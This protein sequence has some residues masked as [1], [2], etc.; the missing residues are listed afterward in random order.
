MSLVP[1]AST[2][3]AGAA[4]CG[5]VQLGRL[6]LRLAGL[7]DDAARR[8]ATLVA[9]GLTPGML[10]RAASCGPDSLRLDVAGGYRDAEEPE[11]LARRI[12]DAIGRA[13]ARDRVAGGPVGEGHW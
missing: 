12:V 13:L 6:S 11:V 4:S 8:L 5:D 3:S 10:R 1:D 9:E 7:D 2:G